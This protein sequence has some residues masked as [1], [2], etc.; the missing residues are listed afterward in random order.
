[1]KEFREGSLI[2]CNPLTPP[3][4][5]PLSHGERDEERKWFLVRSKCV[6]IEKELEDFEEKDS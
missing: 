1:M 4:P 3:H 5:C 2:C 6:C